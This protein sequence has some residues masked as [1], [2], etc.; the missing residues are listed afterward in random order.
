MKVVSLVRTFES[1]KE[2]RLARDYC[3]TGLEP[4]LKKRCRRLQDNARSRLSAAASNE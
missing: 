1:G 3:Q 4:L 2:S